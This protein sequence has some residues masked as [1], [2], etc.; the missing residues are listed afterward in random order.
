[1]S[2][3]QHSHRTI[4]IAPCFILLAGLA[5]TAC[6]DQDNTAVVPTAGS[7]GGGAGGTSGSAGTAGAAGSSGS[8]GGG[9]SAGDELDAGTDASDASDASNPESE[10]VLSTLDAYCGALTC[11]ALADARDLLRASGPYLRIIVQRP[12][13]SANGA[14]RIAVSGDY[15]GHS[16]TYV[17]D[18][19][20]EQLVG[21]EV[22]DDIFECPEIEP[23]DPGFGEYMGYY[24]EASPDCSPGL[25]FVVPD[26]CGIDAGAMTPPPDAGPALECVL[27]P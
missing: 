15:W 7:G 23:G 6:G 5:S 1:M 4:R 18:A 16:R 12:C 10:C 21:V 17:Y 14:A 2:I 22:I 24:G 25:P 27:T 8:G 3:T 26:A 13:V 9:G 19:E 11:P 20:S